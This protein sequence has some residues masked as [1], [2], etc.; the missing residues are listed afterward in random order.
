LKSDQ[1]LELK[2]VKMKQLR[3]QVYADLELFIHERE[4]VHWRNWDHY[5]EHDFKPDL[6]KKYDHFKFHCECLLMQIDYIEIQA[7]TLSA[8]IAGF[9][10]LNEHSIR[11]MSDVFGNDRHLQFWLL[12]QHR[13]MQR[14]QT[15]EFDP[16]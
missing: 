2:M 3:D 1:Q 16:S 12:K 15:S 11:K 5:Y 8:D 13:K 4:K 6:N 7:S 9:N 14:K 10:Q